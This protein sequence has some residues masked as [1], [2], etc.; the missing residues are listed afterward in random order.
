MI[1]VLF[2]MRNC[3]QKARAEDPERLGVIFVLF[4][5]RSGKEKGGWRIWSVVQ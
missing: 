1:S 4:L 2:L 5:V 3:K